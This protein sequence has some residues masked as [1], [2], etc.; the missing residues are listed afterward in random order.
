MMLAAVLAAQ[1]V[2]FVVVLAVRPPTPEIYSLS[3]I[4]EMLRTG[5][6]DKRRFS[7]TSEPVFPGAMG[8][9]EGAALSRAV[10]ARALGTSPD[11]LVFAPARPQSRPFVFGLPPPPRE[12]PYLRPGSADSDPDMI[13]GPFSASWRLPDGSWRSLRPIRGVLDPWQ[14]QALLA[15]TGALVATAPFAWFFARR[16]A[17]PIRQFAAAAERLGRDPQAPQLALDGPREIAGAAATFNAMQTRLQ[18]YVEGRITM[19]AAIAHDMRTPLMRLAF[20]VEAVPEG[21]RMRLQAEI[22]EMNA[23]IGN[24]LAFVRDMRQQSVRR[25]F[26]LRALI[27]SVCEAYADLGR[28]VTLAPGD[29]MVIEADIQGIKTMLENLIGNALAYGG[30]AS[31]TLRA[32]DRQAFIEIEDGGPGIPEAEMERVF[33]P[34][35]RLEPSRSRETGGVG[36]GLASARAVV[37]AHGGGITLINLHPGLRACVVLPL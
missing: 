33:E 32:R 12:P 31:V 9:D 34:F 1:L 10:L 35:H 25:R 20:H 13:V 4:A 7:L 24:A 28:D 36:L 11:R 14:W 5:N 26:A 3:A 27:E 8:D 18:R 21:L 15:L 37:T 30:H 22:D 29:E 19:V 23:M 16:L 2:N 6:V 17:R